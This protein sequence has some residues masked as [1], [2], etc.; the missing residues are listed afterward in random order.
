MWKLRRLAPKLSGYSFH[1]YATVRGSMLSVLISSPTFQLPLLKLY[2]KANTGVWGSNV[3]SPVLYHHPSELLFPQEKPQ[4]CSLNGKQWINQ[5][6]HCLFCKMSSRITTDL[7]ISQ[8]QQP[9]IPQTFTLGGSSHSSLEGKPS[10][11]LSPRLP[12]G[13]VL[14]RNKQPGEKNSSSAD[15]RMASWRERRIL[16]HS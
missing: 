1:F 15:Y 10:N 9:K 8:P 16:P 13:W 12:G 6:L 2:G 3:L 7:P 11:I 14:N 5:L 4:K